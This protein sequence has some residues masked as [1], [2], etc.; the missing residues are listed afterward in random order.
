MILI[1]GS[2]AVGGSL[3]FWR[4]QQEVERNSVRLMCI[5]PCR[6]ETAD[7]GR[8]HPALLPRTDAAPALALVHKLVR[9]NWLDYDYIARHAA[10]WEA[11]PA[12]ALRWPPKR[13]ARPVRHIRTTNP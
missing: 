11:L 3:Y 13:A 9:P 2:N 8:E 10:G 1:W 4:C 7:K 12:R 5:D 6:A